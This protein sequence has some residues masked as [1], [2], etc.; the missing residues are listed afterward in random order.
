M[1]NHKHLSMLRDEKDNLHLTKD[2]EKLVT[3]I[4]NHDTGNRVS[5]PAFILAFQIR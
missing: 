4:C 2:Q 1:N 3:Y 5:Q